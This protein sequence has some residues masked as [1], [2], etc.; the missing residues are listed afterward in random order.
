MIGCGVHGSAALR[1]ALRIHLPQLAHTRS[2]LEIL[3][4]TFCETQGIPIPQVNVYVEGWLV[5]AHWP[6]SASSSRSMAGPAIGR[7]PSSRDHQR[8]LEL[9]AAGYIVLRYTW[10]QLTDTPAAVAA[11]LRRYL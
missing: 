8:D 11:D 10:R 9:R 3:L 7:Q 1:A 5:D 2:E 4:L 6:T